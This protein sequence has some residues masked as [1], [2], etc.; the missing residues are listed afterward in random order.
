MNSQVFW[1]F[2][3]F[4][5]NFFVWKSLRGSVVVAQ[6]SRYY[7]QPHW[8]TTNK[9]A[10]G[11][12]LRLRLS[13]WW[14]TASKNRANNVERCLLI[15]RLRTQFVTILPQEETKVKAG[16]LCQRLLSSLEGSKVVVPVKKKGPDDAVRSWADSPSGW[17]PDVLPSVLA[18]VAVIFFSVCHPEIIK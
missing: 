7:T 4:S 1:A 8:L 2:L 16:R 6:D 3:S 14:M 10:S 13:S 17:T 12:P 18:V 5:G 11:Q 15:C 9:L